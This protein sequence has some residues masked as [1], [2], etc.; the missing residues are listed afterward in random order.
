MMNTISLTFDEHQ[1]NRTVIGGK[2]NNSPDALNISV[3]ILN[4]RGSHFKTPLFQ[5]LLECNFASIVSIENDAVNYSIDEVSKRFPEIKFIIPLEK[6]TDGDMINMAMDEVSS[7]Y[8]LVIRDTLC[9]P[10]GIILSRLAEHLTKNGIY[11]VV[12]RL[13]DNNKNAMFSQFSPFAERSHFKI[14]KSLTVRDGM[15]T[16]YPFDYIALYNRKKFIRLG[17]FDYSITNAYWQ[18]LDLAIRSWLFGEETK[19]TTALQFTYDVEPPVEDKTVNIDYLKYYLKN[20]MPR[21]KNEMGIIKGIYF[22]RFFFNSSCGYLE[23]RRLFKDAKSWVKKN[24]FKFKMDLR[25]LI[26]EWSTEK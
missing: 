22:I 20:E 7:D 4:S 9:I 14:D 6:A 5:N 24:R 11:C 1:I 19:V 17:G 12:Q 18:N 10:S 15:K 23:A 16:L 3:I 25:Q 2:N 8:V 21:V 26:E 13:Q